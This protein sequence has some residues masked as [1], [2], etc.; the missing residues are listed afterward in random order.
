MTAVSVKAVIIECGRVLLLANDRGEWELPGGRIDPGESESEALA[1]EIREELGVT[2]HIGARLA[3]DPFEVLPGRM[4]RIVSYGCELEGA[5]ALRLSDEH[6][7][8]LWAP[9]DALGDL[10]LPEVYRRAVG[11][12]VSLRISFKN[13]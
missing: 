13:P 7:D 6:R 11:L 2:A 8:L 1:R 12:W 4:V 5:A 3:D 10:P 9:A